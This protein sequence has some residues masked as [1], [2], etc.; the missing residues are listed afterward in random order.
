[1]LAESAIGV[2]IEDRSLRQACGLI[3]QYGV[4]VTCRGQSC[5]I[6]KYYYR[7]DQPVYKTPT[8]KMPCTVYQHFK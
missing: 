6:V 5:S 2:K 1:M 3:I 4:K 7:T 8:P